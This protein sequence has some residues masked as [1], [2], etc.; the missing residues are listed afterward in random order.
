MPWNTNEGI[1]ANVHNS[2]MVHI[3]NIRSFCSQWRNTTISFEYINH[4]T[5]HCGAK[6]LSQQCHHTKTYRNQFYILY[7]IYD[8]MNHIFFQLNCTNACAKKKTYHIYW[9]DS[10]PNQF[11]WNLTHDVCKWYFSSH[12][13]QNPCLNNKI[14]LFWQKKMYFCSR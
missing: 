3:H 1:S 11:N 10:I 6:T 12:I 14:R 13:D 7:I 8:E 5:L 4:L 9:N 2:N